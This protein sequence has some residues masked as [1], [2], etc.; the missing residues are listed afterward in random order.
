[1]NEIDWKAQAL[2]LGAEKKELEIKLHQARGAL[3][4]P[5]PHDVPESDIRCGLCEEKKKRIIEAEA[6]VFALCK[7]IKIVAETR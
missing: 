3:G 5:V 7:A 6:Q 2:E 4:Y 1:M